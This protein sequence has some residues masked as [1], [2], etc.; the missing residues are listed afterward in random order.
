VSA[1]N[2]MVGHV[3]H[4]QQGDPCRYMLL[5][6]ETCGSFAGRT[7]M[8]DHLHG[9]VWAEE[10]WRGHQQVNLNELLRNPT[11][12]HCDGKPCPYDTTKLKKLKSGTMMCPECAVQVRPGYQH[13]PCVCQDAMQARLVVPDQ[14]PELLE[15]IRFRETWSNEPG[16]HGGHDAYIK[17]HPEKD[18]PDGIL[19][20]YLLWEK[21]TKTNRYKRRRANA[22][23]MNTCRCGQPKDAMC[24][25]CG[26]RPLHMDVDGSPFKEPFT[27]DQ[28]VSE[29]PNYAYDSVHHEFDMQWRPW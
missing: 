18:D 1:D 26:V 22:E 23:A 14:D 20:R 12:L 19:A 10:A 21:G 25:Q 9:P 3:H 13:S 6:D 2:D 4:A 17:E 7:L 5:Q 11:C 29:L 27:F 28:L 8:A 24:M 15:Y 16:R